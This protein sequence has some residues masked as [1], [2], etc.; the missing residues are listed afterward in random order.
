MQYLVLIDTDEAAF[1]AGM[2]PALRDAQRAWARSLN[3][4]GALVA[5]DRLEAPETARTVRRHGGKALC[6]DGP[7]VETK[8][9]LGGYFLVDAADE[10]AALALAATMP[11]EPCTS[12]YVTRALS[13]ALL[14]RGG[15]KPKAQTMMLC[16]GVAPAVAPVHADL[17]SWVRLDPG[18]WP[19]PVRP[20]RGASGPFPVAVALLDGPPEGAVALAEVVVPEGGAIELRPVV[21]YGS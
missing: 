7:F 15:D 3:E 18:E 13:A 6:T 17:R 5:A 1:R 19:R 16:Y 12:L 10:A 21:G 9:H 4:R 8:E 11:I 2:T 20:E 14:P